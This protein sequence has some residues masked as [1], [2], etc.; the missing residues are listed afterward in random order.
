MTEIPFAF[1]ADDDTVTSAELAVALRGH[2][3]AITE[4]V[5]IGHIPASEGPGRGRPFRIRV[6]AARAMFPQLGRADDR[7][8]NSVPP[9]GPAGEKETKPQ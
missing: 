8:A 4:L 1:M 2:Q 9:A 7:P 6:G 3:H 5:R